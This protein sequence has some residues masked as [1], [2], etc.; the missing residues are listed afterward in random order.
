MVKIEEH[1]LRQALCAGTFGEIELMLRAKFVLFVLIVHVT[2]DSHGM[3]EQ[4]HRD[5]IIDLFVIKDDNN[6]VKL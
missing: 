4:I 6:N 5:A 1:L 2:R 3:R